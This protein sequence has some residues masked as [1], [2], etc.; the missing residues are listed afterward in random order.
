MQREGKRES[1]TLTCLLSS[2]LLSPAGS[3]CSA[4]SHTSQ[5]LSDFSA[6]DQVEMRSSPELKDFH[7]HGTA[8]LPSHSCSL[9]ST[10]ICMSLYSLKPQRVR[11]QATN[12]AL[13]TKAREQSTVG[14]G[15]P[16]RHGTHP[17]RA[18]QIWIH[19]VNGDLVR[20][21]QQMKR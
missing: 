12:K 2:P 9:S 14:A 7:I 19:M 6:L 10:N 16:T 20:T 13:S 1:A 18:F 8:H 5:G 11:S 17:L 3:P 4:L 15:Q 21:F